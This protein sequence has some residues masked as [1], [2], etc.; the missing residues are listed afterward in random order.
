MSG[1]CLDICM[2][3]LTLSSSWGN[4]HAT[5][6]R[7]LIRE[8]ARRGHRVTFFEHDKPW[9]RDHRDMPQP[10]WC[11]LHL[12]QSVAELQDRY[13]PRIAAADVLVQGSYVPEGVAVATWLLQS[14]KGVTVFYDIDTPITLAKLERGDHEYI[15][16]HLLGGFDLYLS[17]TGGPTLD[18]LQQR[19]GVKRPRTFYCSVD[20]ELYSPIDE[21]LQWD[22]GYLGT[23]SQD[24]QP[25]LER[26]LVQPARQWAEG[27]F[28]V[29]GPSYPPRLQ[30]P[31]NVQRI[32]HVA[33]SEHRRFYGR[34]RFTLNVTR[35]DMVRAGWSPSV[36]LFE[37]AACGVPIISDTWPGL[38]Q[39]FTPGEEI[40]VAPSTH[41][42][43]QVLGSMPEEQ[44]QHMVRRARARV[45]AQHTAGHRARQFE[46]L[47]RAVQAEKGA[48]AGLAAP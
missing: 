45:L 8:L 38:E 39:L 6:Y 15:A 20:P 14:A 10:P 9:Y 33:P 44:R 13:R 36:R 48:T 42:V 22:L 30:W 21:P 34:Q 25:V 35:A 27:R 28:V 19:Y 26:L 5:T 29:A 7:A 37:A 11:K 47:V 46:Q 12:Y 18:K 23:Y 4:G 41:Q 24:R 32:E 2:V 43:L 3:G 1:D 17:F 16:G 40:V 31:A